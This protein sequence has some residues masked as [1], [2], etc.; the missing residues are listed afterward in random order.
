MADVR[1]PSV[2]G[3]VVERYPG[4]RITCRVQAGQTISGGMLVALTG[5][6]TG[7][8][9][10]KAGAASTATLGIA[11]F[12]GNG[13][14]ADMN[15]ITVATTGAWDLTASAAINAGGARPGRPRR[16]RSERP[17]RRRYRSLRD[18]NRDCA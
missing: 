15:K 16:C 11:M 12:D 10:V 17:D 14:I 1:I 2:T 3:G 4:G 13:D 6:P 5:A 9:V 8:E 7:N 18:G